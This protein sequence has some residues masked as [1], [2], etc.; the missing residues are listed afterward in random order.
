MTERILLLQGPL[1]KIGCDPVTS[2]F[3]IDEVMR[4]YTVFNADPNTRALA[5]AFRARGFKVVYSGWIED[6]EWLQVNA[7]LFDATVVSDPSKLNAQSMFR[8]QMIANN[9]E[10]LYFGVLRGLE[11]AH[12]TYGSDAIVFRLRSD[13]AV[14]PVLALAEFERVTPQSGILL[15]EYLKTALLFNVPDFMQIAEMDTLL[16]IYR[17]LY[18][19]SAS[20]NSYH[21][22]SHVDHCLT[23]LRMVE[24]GIIKEIHCMG[25]SMYDGVAWRGIPRY[26]EAATSP[27]HDDGLFFGGKVEMPAG[28]TVDKLVESGMF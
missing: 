28:L 8:G 11:T 12:A 10:K 15:I 17:H 24:L 22:S 18:T 14:D 9:K 4:C 23:Y 6:A 19:R 2:H 20:G 5:L 21:I 25:R 13:V 27:G 16:T 26:L 1:N 3:P 7:S